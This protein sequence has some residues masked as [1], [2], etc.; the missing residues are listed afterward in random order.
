MKTKFELL[1]EAREVA[2][3]LR[4]TGEHPEL[5]RKI[6]DVIAAPSAQQHGGLMLKLANLLALVEDAK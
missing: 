6:E 5:L 4:L 2:E 3:R 1:A